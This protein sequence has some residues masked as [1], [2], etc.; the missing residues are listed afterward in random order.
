MLSFLHASVPEDPAG[1]EA[2]M[3]QFDGFMRDMGS[4]QQ[5]IETL[6]LDGD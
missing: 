5:L 2:A 1:L 3:T 4:S 6:G